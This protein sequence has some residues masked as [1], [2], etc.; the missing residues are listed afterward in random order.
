MKINKPSMHSIQTKFTS[1]TAIAIIGALGI[2][3]LIGVVSIGKLGRS[4]AEQLLHLMCSTGAMNLE[5]YFDSVEHSTETVASLVQDSLEEAP[6]EELGDQVESARNLFGKVAYNTNGVLTYYFRIDPEVSKDVKGFWYVN[7]DGEGFREHEVTDISQYD[8]DDT[9]SLVWFT[10]PKATGEGVWLP[11]YN[12]ENLDVRVI[13]YNVPVYRYDRFIGV[14]GI[15]IDYGTLAEEV[16]NIKLFDHGYAFILD[17]DSNVIYHPLLDSRL[18]Y[19]EKIALNDPDRVLGENH[20]Q[21]NYDGVEKEAVW[22]P[23]SNGMRLYVTVPVSEINRGWTSLVKNILIASL[24]ILLIVVFLMMRFA[25]RLTKPLTELT[26]AAKQVDEGNYDYELD[27]E[28][29]DEVGALTSTFRFMRDR[30]KASFSDLNS[31]AY[32]DAL[33]GVRNKAAYDSFTEELDMSARA[34]GSGPAPEY[35]IILMDCDGLKTIND[36]YGHDKGDIFLCTAC[37]LICQVYAHSPVFR[38]GGDEFAILLQGEDYR[39]RDELLSG[40]EKKCREINDKAADP[41]DRVCISKGMAVYSPVTDADAKS[42]L[43]RA[44]DLMYEEKK[45]HKENGTAVSDEHRSE[46]MLMAADIPVINVRKRILIAEDVE[47]QREMLGDLLRDD[48]DI[49]FAS[50]G[51]EALKELRS[52]AGGTDLLLLDL[53]MPNMNGRDVLKEMQVDEELRSVPVIVLTVDQESELDCLKIGAM[54]FIP[55]PYPDIEIVKA[56]INKCIELSEDRDLIKHTERD[57]LTGL[58]NK[59]YFFR[60]VE[61]LDQ[62]YKGSSL[63]AVVCGVNDLRSVNKQQG[64]LFGDS[65]LRS[66]GAGI[67]K[68]ARK[69]GGIGCVHEGEIFLLYCPHQDDYG[70]LLKVFMADVF[71]G[72]ETADEV[73]LRFGIYADAQLEPDIEERFVRAQAAADGVKDDPDKTFGFYEFD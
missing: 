67:R 51:V 20:I 24:I 53:Y 4:D 33:T 70:E 52:N 30:L 17:E 6:P 25:G 8:T 58:L 19:G 62:I 18:Q 47:L 27:Y 23:L 13:S 61:R 36:L 28:A 16:K 49:V 11:P 64:R 45:T 42:V 69:T 21:Y 1:L 46:D 40:F 44:D 55:K 26:K 72:K 10:V 37:R 73:S 31:K 48:Y 56:R 9:S 22:L 12:T 57:K 71:T 34:A 2:A 32:K 14:I 41:W 54:D 66:M 59:D 68:L 35:A 60:Y 38:I 29:D 43:H 7:E 50:D 3:T 65:L 39:G 63:D 5:S 15:E